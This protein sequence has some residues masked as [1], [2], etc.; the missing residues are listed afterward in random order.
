MTST[1]WSCSRANR[2]WNSYPYRRG[3]MSATEFVLTWKFVSWSIHCVVDLSEH[4]RVRVYKLCKYF[5][6]RIDS[7]A[8]WRPVFLVLAWPPGAS[9][10]CAC[11]TALRPFRSVQLFWFN[12]RHIV[13][14]QK[15][16]KLCVYIWLIAVPTIRIDQ[17]RRWPMPSIY[18]LLYW[19][20]CF[21]LRI[22]SFVSWWQS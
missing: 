9:L 15:G 17:L 18:E 21:S 16:N 3:G 13:I 5:S 4:Y 14:T 22:D 20:K 6:P 8:L 2:S 7:F 10:S 12:A 19:S 11:M 1:C